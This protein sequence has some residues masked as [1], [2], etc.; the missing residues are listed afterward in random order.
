MLRQL[1]RQFHQLMR[2]VPTIVW[3]KLSGI[4]PMLK[5]K[6]LEEKAVKEG[7]K[8]PKFTL[9]SVDGQSISSDA[10]LAKGPLIISFYR[11]T[12]CP[13]CSKEMHDLVQAWP[14]MRALRAQLI[15]ISP[16]LPKNVLASIDPPEGI[17]LLF[18]PENAL[19]RQFGLAFALPDSY[20]S[21]AKHLLGL[22]FSQQNGQGD[23]P[24]LPV[25]A[26]YIVAQSGVVVKAFVDVDYT[27]RMPSEEII[28]V[29]KRM[30]PS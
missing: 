4:I 24:S 6:G 26:T 8:I 13:F 2:K 20:V 9:T 10:M 18:D 5:K 7:D 1:K 19:A 28:H 30:M 25:P 29:L 23:P 22:D 15:A 12:W 3:V 17:P 11:G 14:D 27:K 16:Q 21:G